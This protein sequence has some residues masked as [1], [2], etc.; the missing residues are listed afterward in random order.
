MLKYIAICGHPGSGKTEVQNILEDE[1]GVMPIDDGHALRAFAVNNLPDV[2]WTDVI[3]QEG[4]MR[5]ITVCGVKM[6]VRKFLGDLGQALEDRFGEAIMP[7]MAL[8]AADNILDQV[9]SFGS[10][11][12]NQAETYL[13]TGQ[14]VVIEVI[15]PGVGPSGN[16]FDLYNE[17]LV[18]M[19]IHNSGTLEQLRQRVSALYPILQSCVKD[20]VMRKKTPLW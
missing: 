6:T 9:F 7:E 5:E 11:R 18:I 19:Q 12:K 8:N 4:K 16:V 14:A 10:V 1:F 13:A 17:Q 15:R 3:T 2:T 20:A